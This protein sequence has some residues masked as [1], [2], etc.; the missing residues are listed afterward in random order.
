MSIYYIIL[1][2]DQRNRLNGGLYVFSTLLLLY[3]HVYGFF[4]FFAQFLF[5]LWK[6]Y[7]SKLNNEVLAAY[8]SVIVGVLPLIAVYFYKNY[9]LFLNGSVDFWIKRP[10]FEELHQVFQ[11]IIGSNETQLV[12]LV[13][14]VVS[15]YGL[16]SIERGKKLDLLVLLWFSLISTLVVSWLVSFFVFPIFRARYLIGGAMALYVL[17]GYGIEQI[18]DFPIQVIVITILIIGSVNALDQ[19][20]YGH[21]NSEPWNKVVDHIGQEYRDGDKILYNGH[22][23]RFALNYYGNRQLRNQSVPAKHTFDVSDNYSLSYLL[24]KDSEGLNTSLE[25]RRS[26]GKWEVENLKWFTG[27]SSRIWLILSHERGKID[28]FIEELDSTYQYKKEHQYGEIKL[29]E[30][31]K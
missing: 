22:W 2:L 5:L 3:T 29:Y 7:S 17:A 30:F 11:F 24:E 10:G 1:F 18:D 27:N 19:E 9:Y 6:Y 31:S 14:L 25:K 8:S 12:Y 26:I 20:V 16:K 23:T 28:S 4:L 21:E 13:L 15:L